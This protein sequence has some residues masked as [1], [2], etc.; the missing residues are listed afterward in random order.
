MSQTQAIAKGPEPK[1]TAASERLRRIWLRLVCWI[2]GAAVLTGWI[3]P[4]LSDERRAVFLN[5][6]QVL[7]F[8]A[9][10]GLGLALP[11]ACLLVNLRGPRAHPRAMFRP[12]FWRL[13]T[14]F[15]VMGLS[16]YYFLLGI[17]ISLGFVQ[18]G[19]IW[20]WE[21][22][23]TL[24]G[25]SSFWRA[26]ILTL[27]FLIAYPITTAMIRNIAAKIPSRCGVSRAVFRS[28]YC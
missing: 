13:L 25:Y 4:Y 27:P 17:P 6:V 28:L 12:R 15:I 23:N 5:P 8:A 26:A 1:S 24:D 20:H 3:A 9:V 11:L 7:P 19:A 22:M 14:A 18:Y 16:P 10:C 2:T 21:R